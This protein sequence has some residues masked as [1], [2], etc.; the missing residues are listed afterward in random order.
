MPRYV[1]LRSVHIRPITIRCRSCPPGHLDTPAPHHVHE[2]AQRRHPRAVLTPVTGSIAR[3]S[4]RNA[5]SPLPG[6]RPQGALTC[7]GQAKSHAHSVSKARPGRLGAQLGPMTAGRS[8]PLRASGENTRQSRRRE[9]EP[10]YRESDEARTFMSL[11]RREAGSAGEQGHSWGSETYALNCS[12]EEAVA[13]GVER[14]L[15]L[16][17]S[18]DHV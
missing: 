11:W 4:A 16:T 10:L 1:R 13:T 3:A 14:Q 7:P 2:N 6:T 12:K 17:K 5:Q 9:R 8:A 18:F 15:S